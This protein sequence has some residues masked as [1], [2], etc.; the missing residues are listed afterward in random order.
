MEIEREIQK[1][2]RSKDF[3]NINENID[4]LE[5]NTG[6]RRIRVDSPESNEKILLRR[7]TDE[8]KEITRS[9]QDRRRVYIEKLEKLENERTMLKRGLF[10]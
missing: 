9:Y 7:N 6:S 1:I 10:G 8:A 4:I 5:S 2:K 3:K